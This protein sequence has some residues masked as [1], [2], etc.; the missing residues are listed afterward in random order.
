MQMCPGWEVC[1]VWEF[2]YRKTTPNSKEELKRKDKGQ[3]TLRVKF[4]FFFPPR[5]P[6]GLVIL[7]LVV[8]SFSCVYDKI[9][10]VWLNDPYSRHVLI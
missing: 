8:F 1:G 4:S 5:S 7:S 9:L 10:G 3:T 2:I 6:G